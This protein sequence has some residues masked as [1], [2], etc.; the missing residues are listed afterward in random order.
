MKQK[1]KKIRAPNENESTKNTGK[2]NLNHDVSFRRGRS[3]QGL[4]WYN[5][6]HSTL[7]QQKE[8]FM[9]TETWGR[10]TTSKLWMHFY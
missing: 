6:K 5:W 8:M 9:P 7:K 1:K 2:I 4:G 3:S 10:G